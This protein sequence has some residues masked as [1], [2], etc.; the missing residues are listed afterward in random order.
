VGQPGRQFTTA[1]RAE[2]GNICFDWFRSVDDPNLY[3]LVEAFRDEAAGKAHVDSEHFKAAMA[4]LPEWLA[5]VPEI[6]H[7][8]TPG[9]GW[10]RMSE[11]WIEPHRQSS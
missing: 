9:D 5:D 2:T 10:S 3:L 11:I 8:D 6:V 1:T 7:V 4:Q